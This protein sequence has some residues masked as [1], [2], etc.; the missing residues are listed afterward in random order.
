MV[1]VQSVHA[2]GIE[3]PDSRSEDMKKSIVLVAAFGLS[4]CKPIAIA[5]DD[6]IMSS[7]GYDHLSCDAL[8]HQRD[9]EASRFRVPP[10]AEV[11][12]TT[13]NKWNSAIPF[14]GAL[15]DL[16]SRAERE[17]GLAIGRV[18]AM[19]RSHARRCEGE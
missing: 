13:F 6:E 4:A 9:A 8:I 14:F 19:N 10:D 7:T 2:D 5:L 15:P 11:D 1:V 16:R 18:E 12:H 3:T 17:R